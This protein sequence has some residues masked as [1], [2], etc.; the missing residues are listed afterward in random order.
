MS[1]ILDVI[2]SMVVVE[3]DRN[4]LEKQIVTGQLDLEELMGA[5]DVDEQ[6]AKPVKKATARKSTARARRS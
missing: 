2:D 6:P 4:W 5:F 3:S 1:I